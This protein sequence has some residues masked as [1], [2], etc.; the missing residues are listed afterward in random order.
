M[1]VAERFE[2]E[3]KLAEFVKN[4]KN[5]SIFFIIILWD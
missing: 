4:K 5:M 1:S 2:Q 3:N